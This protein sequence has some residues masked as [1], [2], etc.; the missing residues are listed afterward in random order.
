MTKADLYK[1]NVY[2]QVAYAL[3]KAKVPHSAMHGVDYAHRLVGRDCDLLVRKEN[4]ETVK[5]IMK[6]VF[7]SLG[8]KNRFISWSWGFWGLHFVKIDNEIFTV[9]IDVAWTY[10]YRIVEL[11]DLTY[12]SFHIE[13]DRLKEF[14]ID[15]WNQYAKVFLL[16]F[17]SS[18]FSK[19]DEKRI[20]EV[21]D[22]ASRIHP[23]YHVLKGNMSQWVDACKN[24]DVTTLKKQRREF[25]LLKHFLLHPFSSMSVLGRVAYYAFTRIMHIHTVLPPLVLEGADEAFIGELNKCINSTFITRPVVYHCKSKIDYTIKRI[26]AY[27]FT[28]PFSLPVFITNRQYCREAI[29]VSKELDAHAIVNGLFDRIFLVNND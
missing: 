23:P 11:T 29:V 8:G 16:R 18:D 6:T 12:L 22:I 28:V 15:D 7:D 14:Y 3:N 2:S 27:F 19:F 21:K 25:S 9:E 13:D 24:F 10:S 26:Y 20:E 4:A 5:T 17:L 1:W